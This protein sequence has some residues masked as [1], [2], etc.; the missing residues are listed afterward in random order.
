MLEFWNRWHISLSFWLR[1]YIFLPVQRSLLRHGYQSRSLIRTILPPVIT[2]TI[3]GIWHNATFA[4]VSW[5]LLHGVYQVMDHVLSQKIGYVPPKDRPVWQQI[6][7]SIRVYLLLLPTWI[8]FASGGLKLAGNFAQSLFNAGGMI[9][10]RPLE[11][12]IPLIGL[13]ASFLLDGLQEKYGEDRA[14]FSLPQLAQSGCIAAAVLCVV[15]SILWSNVPSA[16]FVYQ[17]F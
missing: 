6:L 9:R 12:V 7:L 2:M 11:L 4:L 15:L 5:G 1:D 16:A 17:G 3:S 13:V 14:I 10:V 8:L